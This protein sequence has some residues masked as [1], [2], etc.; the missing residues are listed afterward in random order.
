MSADCRPL[1][2]TNAA[3]AAAA[4]NRRND[5]RARR[6]GAIFR[7]VVFVFGG[8][9]EKECGTR[10][11]VVH[12]GRERVVSGRAATAAARVCQL[13]VIQR[14]LSTRD[15]S[16][17]AVLSISVVSLVDLTPPVRSIASASNTVSTYICVG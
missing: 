10:T 1:P 2:A 14:T 3:A 8:G 15:N 4:S 7:N 17:F 11:V 12:G 16:T 13:S 9:G 5:G 6:A